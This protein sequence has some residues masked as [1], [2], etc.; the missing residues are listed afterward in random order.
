MEATV[1]TP[2][3][4]NL[5]NLLRDVATVYPA[6]DQRPAMVPPN[7]VILRRVAGDSITYIDPALN[8]TNFF[9][10]EWFQFKASG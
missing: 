3:P 7:Y 9:T 5:I 4:T 10:R 8:F 2:A 6:I 1:Y